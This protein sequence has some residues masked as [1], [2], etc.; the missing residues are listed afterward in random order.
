MSYLRTVKDGKRIPNLP[1]LEDVENQKLQANSLTI[2]GYD[3][4]VKEFK[5]KVLTKVTFDKTYTLPKGL[6]TLLYLTHLEL[7]NCQLTEMPEKLANLTKLRVL[8]LS[9]NHLNVLDINCFSNLSNLVHLNVSH[10]ELPY[11]PLEIASL[12]NLIALDFSYNQI[13]SLPFTLIRLVDLKELFISNNNIKLLSRGVVVTLEKQLRLVKFD[14]SGNKMKKLEKPG[15][16]LSLA[17]T[18]INDSFNGRSS[19][20][21]V[22]VSKCFNCSK[23]NKC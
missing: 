21:P 2:S 1:K 16:S 14:I 18:I 22:F 10:N 20:I 6:W 5:N 9:N 7:T 11:I 8:N 15:S 3:F 19:V 23:V 4:D 17:T 12:R 13:N